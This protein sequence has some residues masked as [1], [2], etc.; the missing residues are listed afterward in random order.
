MLGNSSSERLL[1][2]ANTL[3][4][5]ILRPFLGPRSSG[6]ERLGQFLHARQFELRALLLLGANAGSDSP[7]R[8]A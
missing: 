5:S 8:L 6:S 7:N 2:G 1:L 4:G 3:R